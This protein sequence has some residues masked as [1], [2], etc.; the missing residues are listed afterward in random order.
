MREGKSVSKIVSKR[1]SSEKKQDERH[2]EFVTELIDKNR[3]SSDSMT[4]RS[5]ESRANDV[6]HLSLKIGVQNL[7]EAPEDQKSNVSSAQKKKV[8]FRKMLS[9]G[10]YIGSGMHTPERK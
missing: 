2:Y 8:S 3:E 5:S 10:S 7:A 4:S 9:S 1:Y 6:N